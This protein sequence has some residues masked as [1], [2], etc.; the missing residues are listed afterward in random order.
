MP[1]PFGVPRRPHK[2]PFSLSSS[3]C[4]FRPFAPGFCAPLPQLLSAEVSLIPLPGHRPRQTLS[5]RG[6]DPWERTAPPAC[7]PAR[8]PSV[9]HPREQ[10]LSQRKQPRQLPRTFPGT[11]AGSCRQP[12][13]PEPMPQLPVSS[14]ASPAPAEAGVGVE[15]CEERHLPRRS[16]A[17]ETNFPGTNEKG[18]TAPPSQATSCLRFPTQ[19]HPLAPSAQ[20]N[21]AYLCR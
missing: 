16:S 1:P 17:L 4:L 19:R 3:W 9:P 5:H 10:L 8:Q 7:P 12:H 15:G 13:G 11:R 21:T 20:V 18:G 6:R 2:P 14:T